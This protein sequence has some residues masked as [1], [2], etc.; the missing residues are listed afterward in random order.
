MRS[1]E[2]HK[3]EHLRNDNID[4]HFSLFGKTS[5]ILLLLK[6]LT[7]SEVVK[8]SIRIYCEISLVIGSLLALTLRNSLTESSQYVERF[9]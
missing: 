2:L 9:E 1:M 6:S 8:V 5:S 4:E 7:G 3:W